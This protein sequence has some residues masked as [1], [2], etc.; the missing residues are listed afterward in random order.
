MIMKIN[1]KIAFVLALAI[2]ASVSAFLAGSSSNAE[3]L[4]THFNFTLGVCTH[5]NE[6]SEIFALKSGVKHFRTDITLSKSQMQLLDYEHQRYNASYLGILDYESLPNGS[7]NKNWNLSVWNESVK[8]AVE[9]YPWIKEWEI[10]NEPWVA[11]FQTG[12]VNGSA[13]NYFLVIRS[14]ADEIRSLEP[15]AT[16][17][18]FG[19]APIGSPQIFEWYADVWSYGAWKYCNAISIHAY[20]PGP[21]LGN[22]SSEWIQYLDAY[23]NLT[24]KPIFITE[25]GFPA[26]SKIIPGYSQKGQ[27]EFLEKS[28]QVF[29]SLPYIR[30]AYWY[31][32]WGLS[33]GELGNNYGLL[34]LTNPSS[35][36]PNLA[37]H[38]FLQ[39][40]NESVH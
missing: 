34:N 21:Y 12:M 14:A 22:F 5:G 11:Q 16:I 2:L 32:L 25:F 37:W 26:S 27:A 36:T 7:Q 38:V 33:D 6:S 40:N 19:G 4:G 29:A 35:G 28:L 8:A 3:I 23:E 15:N 31:D 24:H 10:W 9:A 1:K 17:V 20:L 18:C 13:Y 30:Q 39:A